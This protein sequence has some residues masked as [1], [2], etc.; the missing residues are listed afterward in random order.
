MDALTFETRTL[1]LHK[2]PNTPAIT[3]LIDYEHFCGLDTPEE[4]AD[5]IKEITADEL[6]DLQ[7]KG[8]DDYQLIDVREPYEYEIANLGGELIPLNTIEDA[9]DKI[10]SNK[11]VVLHCRSGKR[12]AQAIETL[13]KKYGFDN[14]Y[15]LK[16]GILAWAE[17]ID[18]EMARY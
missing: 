12:S 17:Q 16:G 5:N 10:S 1:K 9:I 6:Y 7:V 14:L 18:H 2:D 8:G 4:E 3:T 15:N 11:K 13:Q